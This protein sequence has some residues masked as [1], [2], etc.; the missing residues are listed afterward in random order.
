MDISS[1]TVFLNIIRFFFLIFFQVLILNNLNLGGYVNPYFY[2]LFILLLPFNTPKWL[3]L[4][5]SFLLGLGVDIFTNTIGL[6]AAA[7]VLMAF[8]RPFVI[9]IISDAPD[10]L[11]GDTPSIKNQG[12]KWFLYYVISMVLIHHFALFYLEIFRFSE[13]FNTLLRVLLSSAFTIG[14]ILICEY[15]FY[16]N[17][18]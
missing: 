2:I 11:I 18:K 14:L 4:L 6:N 3:L 17:R 1:R 13:F 10:S 9:T 8:S 7:C 15:L 5:S 12:L 16:Y